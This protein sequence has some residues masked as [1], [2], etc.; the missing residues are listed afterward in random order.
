VI[1]A[2]F[3]LE[4]GDGGVIVDEQTFHTRH[5]CESLDAGLSAKYCRD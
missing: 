2:E 1:P 3:F 5:V 4:V